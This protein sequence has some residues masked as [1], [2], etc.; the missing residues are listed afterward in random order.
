MPF[1]VLFC[2][3]KHA[4]I[5]HLCLNQMIES[6]RTIV[7]TKVDS[8][9]SNQLRFATNTD[10]FKLYHSE[11]Y[12][13]LAAVAYMRNINDLAQPTTSTAC[14]SYTICPTP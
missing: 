8:T 14:F 11:V 5:W 13:V 2:L 12:L 10:Q 1:L 6:P 3:P 9:Q 4:T 7:P